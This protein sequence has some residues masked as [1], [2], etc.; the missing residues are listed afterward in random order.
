MKHLE[1][2]QILAIVDC[3][4]PTTITQGCCVIKEGDDGSL[5]YVLE[6][7]RDAECIQ[8]SLCDIGWFWVNTFCPD[9]KKRLEFCIG[10][11][12]CQ[13]LVTVM[14]RNGENCNGP[15][16]LICFA[17]CPGSGHL[18]P[19]PPCIYRAGNT[20]CQQMKCQWGF[21]DDETRHPRHYTAKGWH[22]MAWRLQYTATTCHVN[23]L[24]CQAP[25][26]QT[27]GPSWK[28]T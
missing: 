10:S 5:V 13:R 19:P 26:R 7:E 28:P 21:S 1:V 3:M 4:H 20:W 6:G 15:R 11:V 16:P 12:F 2:D 8:K 17:N 9:S 22:W 24:L 27:P 25:P 18:D 14:D 23:V